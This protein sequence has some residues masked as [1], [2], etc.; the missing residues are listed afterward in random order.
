M[1]RFALLAILAVWLS[2]SKPTTEPNLHG[3]TLNLYCIGHLAFYILLVLFLRVW[4][5]LIVRK[6]GDSVSLV[7]YNRALMLSRWLIPCW[8]TIGIYFL[9]WGSIVASWLPWLYQWPNQK[10]HLT[11]PQA[12][13]GTLPPIAAWVGLWWAQ[14]PVDHMFRE[15]YIFDD[16]AADQHIH[17]PPTL[18]QTIW[19]NFRLQILFMLIPVMFLHTLYDLAISIMQL[20]GIA[21]TDNSELL[22]AVCVT[23]P[24]F[25]AVLMLGPI[26]L[27]WILGTERLD[28]SPL[29]TKLE[30]LFKSA[31]I[32]Y[33]E[34]LLWKTNYTMGNA[35]VMGLIPNARYVLLSDLL[36]E[37]MSDEHIEAVFA[38][39]VGHVVHKH[40]WWYLLFAAIAMLFMAGPGDQLLNLLRDWY[41]NTRNNSSDSWDFIEGLISTVVFFSAFI[42]AFG[43]LSPAFERQADVY[44]ARTIQKD[45][46]VRKSSENPILEYASA[47]TNSATPIL[48]TSPQHNAAEINYDTPENHV[49]EYGAGVFTGALHQVAIINHIPIKQRNLSHGSIDY[50]IRALIAMS[51]D[52][53]HTARFDR[54]MR[55]LYYF[56]FALFCIA[57]I[58]VGIRTYI[59]DQE[60]AAKQTPTTIKAVSP[61]R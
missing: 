55:R 53:D 44:A 59:L 43:Y 27:T 26:F 18:M 29:R 20:A 21:F 50:R 61:R 51:A 24:G 8:F 17:A 6:S 28:D 38:H 40:L 1:L 46:T 14:F 60:N 5:N 57:S 12:L 37:S 7:A 54:R 36:M 2:W 30:G 39:E 3:F 41:V 52:A 31:K 35:A 25:L 49:G 16:V 13:M 10:I 58:W 11:V 9:H 19:A 32:G 33:R 15:H 56:L 34:I 23:I 47:S 42:L 22:I 4:S 48:I 45:F